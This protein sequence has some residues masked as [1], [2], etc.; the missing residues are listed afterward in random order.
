MRTFQVTN[1]K[2][3]YQFGN[4][5]AVKLLLCGLMLVIC[6]GY[7]LA[8][9]YYF[10]K[11]L[12]I[13]GVCVMRL[14][15]AYADVYEAQFQKAG[16]LNLAGKSMAYRTTIHMV[17][18]L[19][20]LFVSGNLI[21]SLCVMNLAGAV[22]V[23]WYDIRLMNKIGTVYF[24]WDLPKIKEIILSC[25]PLFAGAFC[26]TYILSASRIAMD[27]NMSSTFQAYYQI[28][29]LPVSVISLLASFIF[30][31]MLP[32]LAENYSIKII[33]LFMHSCVRGLCG[34]SFLLRYAWAELI[35]Q[36]FP[37]YLCFQGVICSR[38]ELC[39]YF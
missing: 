5:H 7:I 35:L 17:V 31:L 33:V 4:Y 12:I 25:L 27:A 37:F 32:G 29:F 22:G 34:W 24:S 2:N 36:G 26:C 3:E 15:D 28:I 11:A 23:W 6:V 13:L 21:F 18:L 39:L 19:G 10:E 16:Y 9:G 30:R 8:N 14:W 1:A 20:C 38:T